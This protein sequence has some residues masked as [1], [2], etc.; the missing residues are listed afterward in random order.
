MIWLCKFYCQGLPIL[1]SQCKDLC[2][3]LSKNYLCWCCLEQNG[4][5]QEQLFRFFCISSNINI[6][7][8][9]TLSYCRWKGKQKRKKQKYNFFHNLNLINPQGLLV[10]L[11]FLY[12]IVFFDKQYWIHKYWITLKNTPINLRG[13]LRFMN[14]YL[15]RWRLEVIKNPS[16]LFFKFIQSERYII[17]KDICIKRGVF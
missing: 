3:L 2:F 14:Y 15:W 11:Y 12:V 16:T 5:A 1:F 13:S 4:S 7:G 6:W 8:G 17:D 9:S 10:W